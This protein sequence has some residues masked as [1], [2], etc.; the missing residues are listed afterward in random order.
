VPNLAAHGVLLLVERLLFG[1]CDVPV[2][3]FGHRAFLLADR[4]I[5]PMKLIGP[6]L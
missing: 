6:L 5:F 3:E 1:A 4:A 2:V